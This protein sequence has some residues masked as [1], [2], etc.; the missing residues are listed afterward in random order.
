MKVVQ[1]YEVIFNH[2]T[3]FFINYKA[4]IFNWT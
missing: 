1:K 4:N 3:I 2:I